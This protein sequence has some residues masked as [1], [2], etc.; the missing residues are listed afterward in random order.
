MKFD[1]DVF[2]KKIENVSPVIARKIVVQY[3][4]MASPFNSHLHCTLEQ[5]SKN[6]SRIRVKL[7]RSVK[8]HLGGVH[9][10]A[11]FTLGETC[12]G[13]LI[14]KNFNPQKFRLILKDA[15]IVYLKQAREHVYGMC[16][17]TNDKIEQARSDHASGQPA[18]IEAVT[19]IKNIND[20]VLCE[21]KTNWQVK[22]WDQVKT[23]G[24]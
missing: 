17:F 2:L 15:S 5:W 9:A 23:K 4:N 20:E 16:E 21:V 24:K 12:A 22:T 19:L 6:K 3:L 13:L 10:G 11:L 14:L 18:L 7:H 8:N 1:F